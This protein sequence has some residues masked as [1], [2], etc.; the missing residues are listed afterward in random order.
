MRNQEIGLFLNVAVFFIGGLFGIFFGP[1]SFIGAVPG[2]IV[3]GLAAMGVAFGRTVI[4]EKE[5]C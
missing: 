3:F 5:D 1:D 2:G 4:G